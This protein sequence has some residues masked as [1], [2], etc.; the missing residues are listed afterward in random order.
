VTIN[1]VELQLLQR[2]I[3][4]SEVMQIVPSHRVDVRLADFFRKHGMMSCDEAVYIFVVGKR[5]LLND[6]RVDVR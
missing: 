3:V 6:L 1:T 2:L 5:L 4:P